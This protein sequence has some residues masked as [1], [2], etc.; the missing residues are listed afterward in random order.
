LGLEVDA[1]VM[2]GQA[3]D[4]ADASF[5]LVVLNLILA[6]IPDPVRC[7]R[8]ADRVLKPGGRV[9]IFDKFL[10]DSKRPP[11]LFRIANV[12]ASFLGTEI[13]RQLGPI[14]QGS[15]LAITHQEAAGGGG[16]FKIFLLHKNCG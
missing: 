3:L 1:R 9:L 11:L 10:P 15:G 7:L 12:L 6:V 2:D 8:E 5:D 16:F 4:F 13:T 14:L